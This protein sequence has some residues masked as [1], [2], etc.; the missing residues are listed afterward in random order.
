MNT[1]EESG[2]IPDRSNHYN[3]PCENLNLL[4]V[5]DSVGAYTAGP[6]CGPQLFA[7]N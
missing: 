7:V 2:Q 1:P 5:P 3:H 4:I 6:D